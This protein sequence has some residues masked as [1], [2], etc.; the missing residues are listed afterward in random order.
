MF[1]FD[2][3]VG[4]EKHK[5][6]T[7]TAAARGSATRRWSQRSYVLGLVALTTLPLL[8]I[9]VVAWRGARQTESFVTRERQSL[10]EARGLRVSTYVSANL[11]T[12]QALARSPDIN[13]LG[14]RP[15]LKA[16]LE[17][18]LQAAPDWESLDIFQADGWNVT[19][20]GPRP[21]TVNLAD[22]PYFQRALQ[23]DQPVVGPAETSERTGALSLP[24][25]V[26]INF[27]NGA[28]GVLIATLTTAKLDGVLRSEGDAAGVRLLLLDSGGNVI[29][30]AGGTVPP[31]LDAWRGQPP[32]EA[33]LRGES[34]T[35]R[36][37]SPLDDDTLVAYAP[38]PGVG[39]G[40]LA[41]QPA[42]A[43]F[44][45]IQRQLT[46][47]IALI[48]IAATLLGLVAWYL[49]GRLK[50]SYEREI[51]ALA[52][53]DDFVTAASHDLK[54]PL[55]TIKSRAQLLRRRVARLNVPDVAGLDEGLAS[56]DTAATRLSA[57]VDELLDVARLRTNRA[58]EL[59]RQSVDLVGLVRAVAAENLPA[60]ERHQVVIETGLPVVTVDADPARLE[61]VLD[62]LLGN[63]VKY[64][65]DGGTITVALACQ[66]GSGAARHGW[67]VLSVADQGIGI[68][69]ADLPHLFQPFHR[70]GNVGK[71]AGT[72][73]GLAGVKQIVE[74]HGGT[75]GVQS[76][77]GVGSTFTIWLPLADSAA[78]DTSTDCSAAPDAPAAAHG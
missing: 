18:A 46:Q 28:R 56:I 17:A 8:V 50:Q 32:A 42:A 19:G 36:T 14:A 30:S 43:A 68:P 7:A 44:G 70:A 4:R 13:D 29:A 51:G 21:R 23:S 3:S 47:Q 63:A 55:T 40:I 77:E 1:R 65:P 16:V 66:A 26:P 11:A 74:Q 37:D 24:L 78:G 9:I 76:T 5:G 48:V 69:A 27:V 34:G 33:A 64:S 61:R 6:V 41:A 12:A 59:R 75:I 57:Q 54:N 10:A 52:R 67:A 71:V 72:G 53:V 39:W 38:V 31:A 20:T 22:R 35:S 58:L 25:A 62:N 2:T 73:I 45:S 49:G 15:D 60:S